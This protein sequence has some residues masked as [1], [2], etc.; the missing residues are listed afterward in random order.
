MSDYRTMACALVDPDGVTGNTRH[1]QGSLLPVPHSVEIVQLPPD[2]GFYLLYLDKNGQ[3][4]TDTLGSL[5]YTNVH[6]KC[7]RYTRMPP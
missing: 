5:A 4:Q 2:D 6:Q 3:E 7:D 1:Y